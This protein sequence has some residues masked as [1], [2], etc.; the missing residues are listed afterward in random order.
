ME[1]A[2]FQAPEMVLLTLLT[3]C[4]AAPPPGL[5]RRAARTQRSR[6]TRISATFLLAPELFGAEIWPS[7]SPR[8]GPRFEASGTGEAGG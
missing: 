5:A 8:R 3:D 2:E 4:A 6:M 1:V 7:V